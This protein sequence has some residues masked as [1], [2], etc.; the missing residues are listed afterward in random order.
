MLEP[1]NPCIC[2]GAQCEQCMFGYRSAEAN[3]KKKKKLIELVNL[4]E[5]PN[6]YLLAQ[7][8]KDIHSDWKKQMENLKKRNGW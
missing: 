1:C 2:T 3:K 8:Y 4:G 5:K 6:G 7:R